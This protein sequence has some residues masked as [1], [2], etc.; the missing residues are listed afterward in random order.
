MTEQDFSIEETAEA[1]D[2][3]S[4]SDAPSDGNE[5]NLIDVLTQLADRKWL[6]A[7]VT[8]IAVLAGVVLALV[9]PV[10]YTATT[11]IMPPQQTQSA[12][13]MMI[14]QLTSGGGGSLAA[15]AGGGGGY[16]RIPATS[17][18]AC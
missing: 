9:L 7:K 14:G 16:S 10:R 12:A 18:S 1:M 5:V 6:I 3:A 2:S 8:G 11:K 4:L 17:T 13:S 15:L